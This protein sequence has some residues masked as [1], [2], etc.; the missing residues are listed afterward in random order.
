[1]SS[2]LPHHYMEPQR[3]EWIDPS[4]WETFDNEAKQTIA[5]IP[6]INIIGPHLQN[7]Q[8]LAIHDASSD[9]PHGPNPFDGDPNGSETKRYA[10]GQHINATEYK[11]LHEYVALPHQYAPQGIR[12]CTRK[13]MRGMRLRWQR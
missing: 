1:M 3:P 4:A 8:H 12:H 10:N 9:G 7:D 2:P 11:N 5:S 13:V 6:R